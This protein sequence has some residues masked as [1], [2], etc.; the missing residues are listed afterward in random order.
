MEIKTFEK[1]FELKNELDLHKETIK[2][3]QTLQKE[4]LLLRQRLE[5]EEEIAYCR[6]DCP[7]RPR[8]VTPLQYIQL[9]ANSDHR[10]EFKLNE[11]EWNAI[12]ETAIKM[13]EDRINEIMKEVE[14]I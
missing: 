5:V 1:L 8:R 14:A 3:L 11:D 7:W 10:A 12:V 6:D 9:V 2:K 4:A 13:K